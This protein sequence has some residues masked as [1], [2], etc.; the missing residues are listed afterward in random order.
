MLRANIYTPDRKIIWS[1]D[2]KVEVSRQVAANPELE[3]ALRGHLEYEMGIA[4]PDDP[5]PERA[6][7]SERPVEFVELYVPLR[8]RRRDAVIGYADHGIAPAVPQRH[9]KFDELHRTFAQ[10][11]PLRFGVVR[12]CD[13]QL[14]FQLSAQRVLELRVGGGD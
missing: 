11:C 6:H 10:M 12:A 7:L 1:S 5:K 13:T 8:D 9:V 2:P 3:H 4:G 14:V